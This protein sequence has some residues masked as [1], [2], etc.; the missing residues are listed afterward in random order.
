MQSV[1]KA[2]LDTQGEYRGDK[3]GV[4]ITTIAICGHGDMSNMD[5][6][7]VLCVFITEMSNYLTKDLAA[8]QER[9]CGQWTLLTIDC[10]L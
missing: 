7:C 4:A 9:L 5:S 1:A 8:Q 10:G 3:G 6:V 2:L